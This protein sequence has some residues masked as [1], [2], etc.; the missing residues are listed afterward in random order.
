MKN[1]LSML[2][3]LMIALLLP[4]SS[5]ANGISRADIKESTN[6]SWLGDVNGDGEFT[7][8]D[9]TVLID[10]L[11]GGDND[12]YCEKNADLN[13]DGWV[14]IVDATTLIDCLL[15][16]VFPEGNPPNEPETKTYTVNGVSFV[17]VDVEGGT[18][19]MGATSE[20]TSP[21]VDES[22]VHQVT[23]SSF[24]LGQT[25][26]TQQLWVAEM[27]NNP[28]G[29][30]GDLNLPVESVSWDDCQTFITR[31]NELT[32]VNFRL[33][34]EAEWEYA[35]RGGA[36]SRHYEYAGSNTIENVAWCISNSSRTTHA[37]GQLAPNEL[38]LYD[39]SGNVWE[40]CQD[41]YESSYNSY[42]EANPTGP[43]SG[44]LR[45]CRG[46][47]WGVSAWGCR[48][49]NRNSYTPEH[50]ATRLGLRLAL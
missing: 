26:V 49:A 11:L 15:T 45:V 35:A 5:F 17:M 27:G 6:Q 23:L 21:P 7:I 2:F 33:P 34:T 8:V 38:Y 9:V 41:W 24:S 4:I 32:G 40:W 10:Y 36:H 28:S 12:S 46:G 19:S 20:Q 47:F 18:F 37:V 25:E 42:A 44:A 48:V 29:F 50:T 30:T 14:T 39:M 16:G 22:P 3:V 1:F 13:Q 31:L 43:D